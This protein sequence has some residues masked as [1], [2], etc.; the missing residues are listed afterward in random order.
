LT[1]LP[2]GEEPY[3]EPAPDE[4][5]RLECIAEPHDDTRSRLGCQFQAGIQLADSLR[6][7]G[8]TGAITVIGEE[9]QFPYQRPPLSKDYMGADKQPQPLPLRAERFFT[10]NDV[11]SRLG[12]QVTAINRAAHTVEVSDGSTIAYSKLVLATGAANRE[13]T[14]P[15][16]GLEGIYGLR[17]LADAEAVHAR[18]KSV[19]SVVVVGTGFIRLEFAAVARKRGLEVTVLEFAFR[20][21][22]RAPSP[23]MSRWWHK[24]PDCTKAGT[25]T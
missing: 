16:S 2:D 9:E 5:E 8:Y 10:E 14:A 22:G 19:S 18:L 3:L 21:M 15:G 7:E 1:C 23:V 25:S 11:D 24:R 13:L 12:V 6:T 17:T 4:E 20:P